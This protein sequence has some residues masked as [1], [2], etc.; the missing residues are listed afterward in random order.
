MNVN[1]QG[2]HPPQHLESVWATVMWHQK[3]K[4]C[5]FNTE[6]ESGFHFL[7]EKYL[8]IFPPQPQ[9]G[10]NLYQ[11]VDTWLRM[12]IA[13]YSVC[14]HLCGSWTGWFVSKWSLISYQ[15]SILWKALIMVRYV[16]LVLYW[17]RHVLCTSSV[18]GNTV[19]VLSICS[20]RLCASLAEMKPRTTILYVYLGRQW[21][22]SPN[23]SLC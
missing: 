23:H 8:H 16:Y 5:N 3:R 13:A 10:P 14:L 15:P 7:L 17:A 11:H 6:L 9:T 4:L 2:F 19:G 18:K 20:S 21:L 1:A 12:Q 22:S